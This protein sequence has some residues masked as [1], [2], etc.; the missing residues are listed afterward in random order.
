MKYVVNV[1]EL[2]VKVKE[3]NCKRLHS[4][5]DRNE[6]RVFLQTLAASFK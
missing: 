4:K 1:V 2:A 6:A 5:T 3:N